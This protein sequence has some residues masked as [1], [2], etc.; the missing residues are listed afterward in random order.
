[1]LQVHFF[2]CGFWIQNILLVLNFAFV[3]GAV[4]FIDL[5]IVSPTNEYLRKLIFAVLEQITEISNI[6]T[7]KN[8]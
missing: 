2:F 6:S 1:M 5:I 3:L 8:L 4:K 7:R